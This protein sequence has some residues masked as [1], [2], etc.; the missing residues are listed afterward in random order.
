[1]SVS[2]AE[3][4]LGLLLVFLLP[5]FGLTRAFFPERRVFRPLSLRTLVEQ[6]T[7]S[8]VLSLVVTVLVGFA[9]LGTSVGVQATWSDPL[10]EASLAVVAVVALAVA[11][12]RGSFARV[13]PEGPPLE[14]EAGHEGALDIVRDLDRMAHEERRLAHQLRAAGERTKEGQA[15]R[16]ELERVRAESEA[17]RRRREAEYAQ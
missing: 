5:G 6:L 8:L 12:L 2:P 1:M 10:V 15:I 16:A 9:W 13:P 3:T 17:V 11:A 7:S 14:P 4:L